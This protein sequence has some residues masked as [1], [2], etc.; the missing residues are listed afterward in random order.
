MSG[1]PLDE[2]LKLWNEFRDYIKSLNEEKVE[3]FIKYGKENIENFGSEETWK[4]VIFNIKS[5]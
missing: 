4:E 3:E 2:N 5:Q 1:N